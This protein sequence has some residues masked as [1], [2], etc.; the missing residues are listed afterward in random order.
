LELEKIDRKVEEEVFELYAWVILEKAWED[1]QT[2]SE[3]VEVLK[4]TRE[5]QST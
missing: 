4:V 2:F 3:A 5:V 1:F